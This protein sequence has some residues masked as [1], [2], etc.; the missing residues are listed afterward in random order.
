LRVAIGDLAAALLGV[1]PKQFGDGGDQ[2]GVQHRIPP[3]VIIPLFVP[4]R[5]KT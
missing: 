1:A 4:V 3:L 2:V 5:A